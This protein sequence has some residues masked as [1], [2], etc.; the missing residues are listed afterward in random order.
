MNREDP[1]LEMV[2]TVFSALGDLADRLV[3]VGG[4][5]AGLLITDSTHPGIRPTMDVDVLVE[6]AA[7]RDYQAIEASLR[8]RGLTHDKSDGAPICRWQVGEALLDLLPIASEILGFS[9]PWYR[10]AYSSAQPVKLPSGMQIKVIDGPCFVATKLTA[11]T[12]RGNNDY[13]ASHDLEDVVSLIDGR[14]EL[15]DEVKKSNSDVRTFVSSVI[16]ALLE[17]ER[18]LDALPGHLPPDIVSQARL[19]KVSSTLETLARIT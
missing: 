11:F 6:V 14:M 9:N 16:A 17:D 18:F 10:H 4:C 3:L 8:Q 19:S 15:T 2:E 5:A 12:Q 13:R 7:L 1:N